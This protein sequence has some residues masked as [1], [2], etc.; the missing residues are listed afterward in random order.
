MDCSHQLV[1]SDPLV[2]AQAENDQMQGQKEVD[3]SQQEFYIAHEQKINDGAA[4]LSQDVKDK[5]VKQVI[6]NS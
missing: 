1:D 4:P 6:S 2:A 3:E 5:P